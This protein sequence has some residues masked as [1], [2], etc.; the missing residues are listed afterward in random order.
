MSRL[1]KE[2]GWRKRARHSD[3]PTKGR[4]VVHF[5]PRCCT[6]VLVVL[7]VYLD[8]AVLLG[9]INLLS[10]VVVDSRPSDFEVNSKDIL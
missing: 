8:A 9:W 3:F 5:V 6:T 2:R 4:K 10:L 7:Q 1:L